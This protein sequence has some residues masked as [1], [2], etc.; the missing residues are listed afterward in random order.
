MRGTEPSSGKA[1]EEVTWAGA[2]GAGWE[3]SLGLE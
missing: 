3:S 1:L 2:G